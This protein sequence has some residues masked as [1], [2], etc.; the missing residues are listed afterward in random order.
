MDK[1]GSSLIDVIVGINLLI[2]LAM[3][4]FSIIFINQK[5]LFT[6]ESMDKFNSFT[7]YKIYEILLKQDS[8]KDIFS[9]KEFFPEKEFIVEYEKKYFGSELGKD[10]YMIKVEIKNEKQNMEREYQ[11][12]VRE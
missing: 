10:F 12:L 6:L 1:K 2:I 11:M 9:D 3:L 8:N 4:C 5:V 7:N